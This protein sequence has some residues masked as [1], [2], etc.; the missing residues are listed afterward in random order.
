VEHGHMLM[1]DD[2]W[3]VLAH[4]A[5]IVGLVAFLLVVLGIVASVF[6]RPRVQVQSIATDPLVL[7]A[8]I[9]YLKGSRPATNVAVAYGGLDA[10]G[11][12]RSGDGALWRS[13]AMLPGDG[14]W[15][16][17]NDS[18]SPVLPDPSGKSVRFQVDMPSGILLAVTWDHPLAP[19]LRSRRVVLWTPTARASG[20]SPVVLKGRKATAAVALSNSSI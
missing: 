2:A 17:I 1:S 4:T 8:W 12:A 15:I 6:T 5:D 13:A 14:E 7:T 9:S 19:G 3:T 16:V 20:I 18:S 10:D 11:V